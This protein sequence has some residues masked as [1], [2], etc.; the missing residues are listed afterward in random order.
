[1]AGGRKDRGM[2]HGRNVKKTVWW[3]QCVR[4]QDVVGGR[5]DKALYD[6]RNVSGQ[7]QRIVWWRQCVRRKGCGWR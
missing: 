4:S 2:Y 1:M 5:R 3:M 7:Q 6:G